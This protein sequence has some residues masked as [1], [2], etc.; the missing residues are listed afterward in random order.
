MK[1]FLLT[2][3]VLALTVPGVFAQTASPPAVPETGKFSIGF[4]GGLPLGDVSTLF[5]AI[6]GGSLRYEV[7]TAKSTRFTITA[8][9]TKF[10]LKSAFKHI[11]S[12]SVVIPVKA[13]IKY[14]S[15]GDFFLEGQLGIV[16]STKSG[17]GTSFLY[18]PGFGYTFGA[19]EASVRYEGW[20]KDGDT[21]S[22]IGLRLAMVFK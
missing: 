3:T 7:P 5:S 4:D 6:V 10:L 2:I 22:Q 16:F 1:K 15:D 13:G 21:S 8:G 9:V 12:T 17:G 18:A 20:P 14:Y 11:G 19:F